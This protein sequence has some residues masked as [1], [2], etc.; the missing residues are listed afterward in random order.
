MYKN[1]KVNVPNS[2][3]IYE[4]YFEQPIETKR[5]V[6]RLECGYDY[7]ESAISDTLLHPDNPYYFDLI[8]VNPIPSNIADTDYKIYN[9]EESKRSYSNIFGTQIS[10]LTPSLSETK[11]NKKR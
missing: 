11:I 5:I 9:P 10:K 3:D 8:F 6:I 1:S 4:L 7:V 2:S